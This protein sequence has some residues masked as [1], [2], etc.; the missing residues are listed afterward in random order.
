M[1]VVS[2]QRKEVAWAMTAGWVR[3]RCP[4]KAASKIRDLS[5]RLF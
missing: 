2:P 1:G 3:D 5:N 4:M